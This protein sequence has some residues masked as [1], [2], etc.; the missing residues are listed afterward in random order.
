MAKTLFKMDLGGVKAVA[1]D[2]TAS[3]WGHNHVPA[4]IDKER[5]L[6]KATR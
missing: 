5:K 6:P 1:L 2:Q 4:F 3:K